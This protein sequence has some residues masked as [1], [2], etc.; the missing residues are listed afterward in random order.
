MP[1]KKKPSEK[2]SKERYFKKPALQPKTVNFERFLT[3]MFSIMMAPVKFFGS[4]KSNGKYEDTIVK[5]M[6]YGLITA[7]IKILFSITSITVLS[8]IASVLLLSFHAVLVSF[9]VAGIALFFAYLAKGEM[10]FEKSF[11]A[12]A[13][14][15]FM[16]PLAFTAYHL[17]FAYPVLFFLSLMI[18]LYLVFLMYNIVIYAL[19]GKEG[20][21][22]VVFGIF[23]A[24][25]VILHF[26][27][28]ADGYLMTKNSDIVIERVKAK[29]NR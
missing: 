12:V 28:A 26:S 6:I 23:A 2:V 29:F 3:D 22:Q 13:S 15:I 7:G 17:A 24:F 10:D 1:I 5:I 25:V 16:Y 4:I 19:K 18:D 8:A 20:V 21:A 14:C 9:G 27:D 11:K